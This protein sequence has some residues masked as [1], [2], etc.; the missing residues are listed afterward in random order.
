MNDPQSTTLVMRIHGVEVPAVAL[1]TVRKW[2]TKQTS[3][4]AADVVQRLR[5]AGVREICSPPSGAWREPVAI[6]AADRL[7][8]IEKRR[9]MIQFHHGVWTVIRNDRII[10]IG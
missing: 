5:L 7:L 3:F 1:D 2:M 8:Q 4:T 10:Y 6:R 9:G